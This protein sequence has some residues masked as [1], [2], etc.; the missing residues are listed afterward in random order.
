MGHVHFQICEIILIDSQ[1]DMHNALTKVLNVDWKFLKRLT[2]FRMFICLE[3]ATVRRHLTHL[4]N[5]FIRERICYKKFK[6]L[7]CKICWRVYLIIDNVLMVDQS[8]NPLRW[9][10]NERESIS[11]RQLHDC[12]LNR[13][14]RHRSKKKTSKICVT[15]LCEG[16]SPGTGEFPAQMASNAENVSIW[17]RH[18]DP[19]G[20]LVLWSWIGRTVPS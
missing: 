18:H 16:N 15:G 1:V 2:F 10:H 19:Y 13:L 17:W 4:S 6:W 9:R 5:T 12:L 3:S 11:H 8:S 20:R 14:F 7:K